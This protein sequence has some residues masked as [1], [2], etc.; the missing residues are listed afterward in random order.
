[1]DTI[2]Y[3]KTMEM[4][5]VNDETMLTV[6][7]K[8]SPEQVCLSAWMFRIRNDSEIISMIKKK[9]P[10]LRNIVITAGGPDRKKTKKKDRTAILTKW[11]AVQIG[12]N[13]RI[14]YFDHVYWVNASFTF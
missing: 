8:D 10:G 12:F 14:V 6:G 9:L 5:I 2:K 4:E 13:R 7:P 3:K 1:M 11:P